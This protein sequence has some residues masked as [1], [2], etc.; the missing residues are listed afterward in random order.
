MLDK[1][2][3]ADFEKAVGKTGSIVIEDGPDATATFVEVRQDKRFAIPGAKKGTRL[4]FTVIL[5]TDE[6]C[7]I[8]DDRMRCV[9]MPDGTRIEGVYLNEI[10][11]HPRP[12]DPPDETLCVDT[13][14]FQLVFT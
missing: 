1:L 10:T 8:Q 5:R 13:R 7:M 12:D 6:A 9:I 2:K 14:F 11:G 3:A 4:P